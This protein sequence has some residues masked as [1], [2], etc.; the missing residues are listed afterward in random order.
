MPPR[1]TVTR[2]STAALVVVVGSAAFAADHLDAPI[3]QA[4]GQVDINDLYAFQSPANVANTVLI[5]TVN[6]FAGNMSPTDFG[7]DVSYEFLIDNT[8]D[9]VPDISYTA[10]FGPSVAGSQAYTV[11]KDGGLFATG[12]TGSTSITTDGA[13]VTAGIFDDP[14]F[15]DLAG[16]NNG[17]SF[18]GTDAF[19]GADVGAIVLEVPSSELNG[20]DSNISVYARTV[21][22]GEQIDRIGRP[23]INTVLIPSARKDEFNEA[24][25]AN[26]FADFSADVEAVITSL[27]DAANA[28]ALSPIL[29]PDVLT[30]DTASA[31]GFLNGRGLVDDVI[32]AE[33]GLLSSGAVT[34]DLVN[35]NDAAFLNVFPYL[36][37]AN[38]P[39]P[40]SLAA[41]AL[42]ASGLVVRRSAKR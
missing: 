24:D 3:V 27:S 13:A 42:L 9:A 4:N 17:F 6:P 29:L 21:Q 40:T 5:L 11:N 23:A 41:I 2:F 34:G 20:A 35:A 16:F 30:F 8:G 12:T 31:A 14:F 7:T 39:E 15:F 19:A 33:L 36:A 18:T 22:G 1:Q 25:P 26:D 37:P 32:D 28:S 10:T 38:V